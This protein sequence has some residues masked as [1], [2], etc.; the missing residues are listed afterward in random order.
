MSTGHETAVTDQPRQP[1][2]VPPAAAWLGGTGALPFLALAL[3]TIFGPDTWTAWAGRALT[4]YGAV[5]L[6]F[7]G[8]I[9]WGMAIAARSPAPDS[10][11]PR[12]LVT[13]VVPSLIGWAALLM[14][15]K[16]GLF[17]MVAAFALVLF[18]DVRASM[19]GEAPDWY[20]KLRIPLSAVVMASLVA[21][22]MA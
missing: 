19:K 20:P 21:G 3:L 7:L 10:A 5:I 12:R 6:S 9:Q 2:S 15:F 4:F 17:M 18:A 16:I 22:A 11:L 13:S 1:S 14:P 8:G